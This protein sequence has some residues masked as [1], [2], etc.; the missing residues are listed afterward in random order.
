M[1]IGVLLF[2]LL[3]ASCAHGDTVEGRVTRGVQQTSF[4]APM[5]LT[6]ATGLAGAAVSGVAFLASDAPGEAFLGVLGGAA[7][8]AAFL[9]GGVVLYSSGAES[10]ECGLLSAESGRDECA[11]RQK[12]T[13]KKRRRSQPQ[14]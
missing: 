3:L 7:V 8:S 2:A 5:I 4:G 6:G 9:V 14:Y 13:Q 10:I 1:K 11:E 12:K